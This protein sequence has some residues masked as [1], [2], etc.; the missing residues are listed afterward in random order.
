MSCVIIK[1]H[2]GFFMKKYL[3]LSIF[4]IMA[5]MNMSF[6]CK[7]TKEAADKHSI[8]A[9]KEFIAKNF[10]NSQIDSLQ[11][12]SSGRIKVIANASIPKRYRVVFGPDC[13]KTVNVVNISKDKRTK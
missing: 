11:I 4:L 5:S 3:G 13:S 6:A 9:V 8:Q 12:L 1:K 10:P 7:M 2:K